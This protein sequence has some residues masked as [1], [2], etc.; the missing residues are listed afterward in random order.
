MKI[1]VVYRVC[2]TF[3]VSVFSKLN[4][5]VGNELVVFHG[6][7]V[8]DTKLINANNIKGFINKNHYT[9]K[10]VIK[11]KDRLIPVIFSPG[12]YNSLKNYDPDVLLIEGSSNFLNNILVYY[13]A[14]KYDKPIVYWSLGRII[15]KRSII[16]KIL[17]PFIHY[18]E[19]SASVCLGYSSEAKKYF[20]SIGVKSEK[21][22]IANNCVDTNLIKNKIKKYEGITDTRLK[23]KFFRLLFVGAL[24]KGKNL[25]KL[26]EAVNFLVKKISNLQLIIV[27]DG[28]LREKYQNY[29]NNLNLSKYTIFTG[30]VLGNNQQ[31]FLES[32]LFVLPGLGG[33]AISEAMAYG[34][35]II[36]STADGSEKDLVKNG[37]NGFILDRN[38]SASEL[39]EKILFFYQNQIKIK[40]F[41]AESSKI[42]DSEINIEKYIENIQKA[43][44]LAY[45]KNY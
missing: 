17:S 8:P 26:F 34:L 1:A 23:N 27:G 30:Q 10:L 37:K 42:I 38:Y 19:K 15:G 24:E 3:R 39:A 11:L 43:L 40:E 36:C 14:N 18:F 41:G 6:E 13:Y 44:N 21:I 2:Q 9:F 45:E 31:Y 22:I 12:I 16:R 32:D 28:S 33:L 5:R 4:E 35:P 29:A 25:E 7:S 20:E